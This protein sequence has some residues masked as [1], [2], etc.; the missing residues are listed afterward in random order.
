[1]IPATVKHNFESVATLESVPVPSD[2]LSF[3][4]I[5]IVYLV[6]LNIYAL[7]FN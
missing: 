3:A 2:L 7:I 4:L 1:M 6:Y 5:D